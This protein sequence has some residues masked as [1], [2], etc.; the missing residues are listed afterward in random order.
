MLNLLPEIAPPSMWKVMLHHGESPPEFVEAVLTEFFG[1]DDISAARVMVH[2]MHNGCA[3]IGLYTKEIA[4]TKVAQ[5]QMAA[6]LYHYPLFVT[7]SRA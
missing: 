4:V 1:K 3:T 6:D 5:M 7:A 2:A